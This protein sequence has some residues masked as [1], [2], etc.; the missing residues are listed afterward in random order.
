MI[1]ASSSRKLRHHNASRATPRDGNRGRGSNAYKMIKVSTERGETTRLEPN[2]HRAH[3]SKREGVNSLPECSTE[4]HA[5][6]G[7]KRQLP[8]SCP[9]RK[10]ARQRKQFLHW[11]LTWFW[12]RQREQWIVGPT[13]MGLSQNAQFGTVEEKQ[14]LIQRFSAKVKARKN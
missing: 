10:H 11:A 9:N 4:G 5:D 14:M 2:Y 12:A 6:R 7:T 8:E 1:E 13:D 3:G